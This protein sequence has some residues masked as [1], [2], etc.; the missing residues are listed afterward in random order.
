M[1][2]IKIY[3]ENEEIIKKGVPQ[4]AKIS[5][6]EWISSNFPS[7]LEFGGE[8]L[9]WGTAREVLFSY[10]KL[11]RQSWICDRFS[12]AFQLHLCNLW[13][14]QSS[15]ITISIQ[16]MPVTSKKQKVLKGILEWPLIHPLNLISILMKKKQTVC[17]LWLATIY[18]FDRQMFLSLYKALVRSP[19]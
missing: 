7:Q 17:K 5:K 14:I 4:S 8:P 15:W 10:V 9:F 1:I 11:N 16:A 6:L 18:I 13:M 3:Y 19:L 12:I 2:I